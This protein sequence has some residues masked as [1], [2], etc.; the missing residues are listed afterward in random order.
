MKCPNC[1][2][3]GQMTCRSCGGRR[4]T[5]ELNAAYISIFGFPMFENRT[6]YACSGSGKEKCSL[7]GGRGELPD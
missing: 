2:G 4:S 1:K 5:T 7:C 6:C 3:T